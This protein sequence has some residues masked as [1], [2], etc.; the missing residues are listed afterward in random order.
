MLS[1]VL[2]EQQQQ[3]QAL[4]IKFYKPAT[5]WNHLQATRYRTIFSWWAKSNNGKIDLNDKP[6]GFAKIEKFG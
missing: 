5:M 6:N 1:A 3:Q 2:Q 4:I